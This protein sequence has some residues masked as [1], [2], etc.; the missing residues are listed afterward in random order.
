MKQQKIKFKNGK[1]NQKKRGF[2]LIELV[3]VIAILGVLAV[4][5]LPSYFSI[6]LSTART[7]AM[8]ATVGAVQAGI[9]LY[10]ANQLAAG[11][12]VSYPS[13]LDSA[14]ITTTASPTILY[15]TSVLQN[16]VSAQWF[17]LTTLI[18]A[19]DTDGS[20]VYESGSDTCYT[21]VPASGTFASST[22]T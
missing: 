20:G 18:Y 22:C 6:S 17:K 3:L 8:L 7:N 14:A 21:Y 4:S 15:F 9:S 12:A 2:T 10:A 11:S 5:A 13:T 1:N 19:Y 16:G